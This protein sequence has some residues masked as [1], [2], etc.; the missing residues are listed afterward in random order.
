MLSYKRRIERFVFAC[1]V[2]AV[3]EFVLATSPRIAAQTGTRKFTL[4]DDI[5]LTQIGTAVVFSPDNRFF[6]VA[7]DR[8]RIDLNRSESILF[9]YSTE[10]VNHLLSQPSLQDEPSPLWSISKST[11]KEGPIISNVRW[12]PDSSGFVFLAKTES[13]NDQLFLANPHKRVVKA[14]TDDD[15]SVRAFDVRSETHFVYAV[16]SPKIKARAEEWERAAATVGTGQDLFSLI[17]P[18]QSTKLSDLCELW[19]VVDGKRFRVLEASSQRP[20]VIHSEGVEALALS[21]DGHYLVTPMTVATIPLEWE[22]LYPP[23]IPSYPFRVRAGRQDPEALN[24]EADISEYVLIDL[25]SG[26]I[27][28]LTC[29]PTGSIA[30]WLGPITADWSAD[31]KAVVMSDTFLPAEAQSAGTGSNRPCVA[32]ADLPTGKLTCVERRREQTEQDDQEQWRADAH[33]VSGKADR[34]I[35]RYESGGST[36]YVRSPSGWRA[37]T[38]A[39]ESVSE[40]HAVDIQIKQDINHPPVL[41]ATDKQGKTSRIIWNPNPQLKEV[42]LG[43]VSVFKWKDKTGHDWIG[44]LYKPPDYIK[45]KRYPLVIQTHGFDER[46]F[47]TSGAFT[48]AFA[49]QELAAVGILVLQVEDCDIGLREEGACQVAGYEAAVQQL[50]TEGLVDPDRVGIIGFSAT[51]YYV[52]DALTTSALRFK[53]ASITDGNNNGYLQYMTDV[54]VIGNAI[55]HQEDATIGASPFGAGLQQWLN[56]SPEFNMNK[57]QTP[58]QVVALGLGGPQVLLMWEPYAALRY[59]NKPVDLIVLSSDQHELT[60]PAARIASQGGTVDWFRFWLKDEEDSDPAKAEQY[61]RWRKLR[62]LKQ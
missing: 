57:V 1:F 30:G 29:A 27:T 51:C 40:S 20:V 42:L 59:L 43:E 12:L 13:G 44:G 14:L 34:V 25:A 52:L 4:A 5:G 28:P 55:A 46:Q 33:F 60:N 26:R 39:S 50:T 2:L 9:V 19:A 11:Y 48:T 37:V 18:A 54:D 62:E 17:F 56:R 10:D 31:G 21:P 7:S 8:G 53:A 35:V 15:Q 3:F 49:A 61:A 41:V 24:G 47:Q 32:V 58:L 22:T 6:I 23:P 16:P 38:P 36:I 45:G